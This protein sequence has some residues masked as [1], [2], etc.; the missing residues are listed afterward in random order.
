LGASIW[1]M[2]AHSRYRSLDM[3]R[4]YVRNVEMFKEHAGA[5]LL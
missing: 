1:K 3:L 4:G 5:A 2:A